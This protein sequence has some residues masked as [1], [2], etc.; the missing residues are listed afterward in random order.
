MAE[1]QKYRIAFM[2]TPDFAADILRALL[3]YDGASVCMV[4]T[5]PDR[6]AGRGRKLRQPQVKTLAL[7]QGL[8][9]RQPDSFRDEKHVA[10]LAE[11]HAD[12]L[13]VAAYGLILPEAVLACARIAPVNVHASILPALRGAAPIQRAIMAGEDKCVTGVSIMHMTRG[14]DSG[15]VYSVTEMA[16]GRHN[17]GS[18]TKE[19]ARLGAGLLLDALPKIATGKLAALPQD[20]SRA[21]YAPKIDKSECALDFADTVARVDAK[22]RALAPNPGARCIFMPDNS[23]G[24]GIG[25]IIAQGSPATCD[26]THAPGLLFNAGQSLYVGCSD[27][28]YE[29]ERLKPHDRKEMSCADFLRG[30]RFAKGICGRCLEC[31]A[32]TF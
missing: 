13:V 5:M 18:L 7:E 10:E 17:A 12:F 22:V 32:A 20:E 27:G 3:A 30:H 14:M 31:N 24:T 23:G 8:P 26:A 21:T 9:V 28:W 25:A 16:V 11:L 1:K 15:P 19:L 2:G 6:Q 4:Y 29:I